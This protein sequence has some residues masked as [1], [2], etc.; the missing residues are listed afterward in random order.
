[1]PSLPK[2]RKMNNVN[3][4]GLANYTIFEAS[5]ISSP[6]LNLKFRQNWYPAGETHSPMVSSLGCEGVGL[7]G[8]EQ[9]GRYF[10]FTPPTLL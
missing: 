2:I 3:K 5:P 4:V 7:L 1:M 8:G 6:H 10:L 9:V